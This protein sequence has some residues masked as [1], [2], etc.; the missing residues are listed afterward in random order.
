MGYGNGMAGSKSMIR[1]PAVRKKMYSKEFSTFYINFASTS[2]T[3]RIQW[4]GSGGIV[5]GRFSAKKGYPFCFFTATDGSVTNKI[6][7]LR[8]IT[9]DSV[10]KG[11]HLVTFNQS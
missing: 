6:F 8:L 4:T 10:S 1:K 5:P 11:S 2:G 3:A 9:A 7:N